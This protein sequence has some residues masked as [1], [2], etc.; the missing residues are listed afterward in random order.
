[1][2]RHSLLLDKLRRH[3]KELNCVD[4]LLSPSYVGV[5]A[6]LNETNG[7]SRISGLC[8]STLSLASEVDAEQMLRFLSE[9]Q[10]LHTVHVSDAVLEEF[11]DVVQNDAMADMV[12]RVIVAL[13]NN[14]NV[15]NIC[16]ETR[17]LVRYESIDH[18]LRSRHS[19][20]SLHFSPWEFVSGSPSARETLS[21][22]FRANQTLER[23]TLDLD[24]PASGAVESIFQA[25]VS[26][27][28]L[29]HLVLSGNL[30][31]KVDLQ[32][33]LV[34][35]LVPLVAASTALKALTIEGVHVGLEES[36]ELTRGISGSRCLTSLELSRVH[37]SSAAT[38]A[39]MEFVRP[40]DNSL[41]LREMKMVIVRNISGAQMAAMLVGSSLHTLEF[42]GGDT[43]HAF[44]SEFTR[45]S[46]WIHLV[47]LKLTGLSYILNEGTFHYVIDFLKQA[48][49]LREFHV[50]SSGMQFEMDVWMKTMKQNGNLWRVSPPSYYKSYDSIKT[51]TV[52]ERSRMETYCQRNRTMHALLSSALD[53]DGA[54][55]R[56]QPGQSLLPALFSCA[57]HLPST[58][59]NSI[60]TGLLGLSESIGYHRRSEKRTN[61][62]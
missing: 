19:V 4:L 31:E 48:V 37:F 7:V 60:L 40:L 57:S 29:K 27:S 11:D 54:E 12:H 9:C 33:S 3:G 26:H 16:L 23:L 34:S 45:L 53:P 22:A 44:L 20:A 49:H 50:E 35:A 18:L 5:G 42:D 28:C 10:S 17:L 56:S 39:F 15:Q 61:M 58:G 14:A 43:T 30:R 41:A 59:P 1:M 13:S 46:P 47:C 51:F 52:E 62:L 6:A 38:T 25:L 32:I 8:A 2:S 21:D 36:Q 24:S 55:S